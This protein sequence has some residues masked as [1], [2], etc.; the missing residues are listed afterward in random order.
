MIEATLVNDPQIEKAPAFWNPD[1]SVLRLISRGAKTVSSA[2]EERDWTLPA[3]AEAVA[4]DWLSRRVDRPVAAAAP[5][6]PSSALSAA[7]QRRDPAL[8]PARR[9]ASRLGSLMH[10]LL[11]YLPELAPEGR[12]R[13]AQAFLGARAADL[14]PLARDRLV[15]A[16]LSVI[17]APDLAALFGPQSKAE[18]AVAATVAL[19]HGGSIEVVG[20]IDRIG[21][22]A[23]FVLVADFKTG[24]PC[25]AADI[26]R[27]YLAQMALYRAALEPL[28]PDRTLRMLLVWTAE[29]MVFTLDNARLDEE[30][31]AIQAGSGELAAKVA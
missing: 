23:E 9:E 5:I 25:A 20:Q 12:L 14:D 19:P 3:P 16:A 11:Q 24:A 1:E 26:P 2:W 27:R 10:V 21:V 8:T 31:A 22:S 28:W 29:P 7:D 17:G 6:R 18:V 30:L 15:D 4:P 13:A